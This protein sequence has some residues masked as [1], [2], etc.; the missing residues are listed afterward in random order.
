[1]KFLIVNLFLFFAV[2]NLHANTHKD[3]LLVKLKKE[4][5]NKSIYD[6]QKLLRIEEVKLGFKQKQTDHFNTFLQLFNEYEYYKFDSAYYYGKKLLQEGIRINNKK[7]INESK[8]KLASLLLHAGMFK[9]T[10]DYLKEIN[11]SVLDKKYKYEYYCLKSGAYSNLAIY[12]NDPNFT[13][14]YNQRAVEYLDSAI[15]QCEPNTFDLLFTLGN[16]QVVGGM[17]NKSPTFFLEILKKYEL[18]AH[19]RAR[20]LTA[21]A[22]FY[23]DESQDDQRIALLA[24]SAIWD[25]RSS[26]RETL[27]TLLLA[28]D[29]FRHGDLDNA[30]I[31]IKNSRDDAG[32]YGNRL[33]KLKIESILPDIA[34]QVDMVAQK[35]NNK[36]MF[37]FLATAMI[38]VIVLLISFVIFIQLKKL[39]VKERIIEEKNNELK[40]INEQLLFINDKLREYATVNEKYIGYFFDVIS[41]YILKLDRLKKNV[42]RKIL[43]KRFGEVLP[44]LHDIDIK[45]E[46]ETLFNTFDS[47]F[48]SIF[49][50]FVEVFNSLLNQEDQIWPKAPELLNTDLR[51]FALMRLGIKDVQAIATILEYS[52]N[53]IYVYK[54]RIKAKAFVSGDEFDAR[55]MAVKA[56]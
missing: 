33:R 28:E 41:G 34:A 20:L 32:F 12:N 6:K 17:V 13:R 35:A 24:E 8:V 54:M 14:P 51:I 9:E 27:A 7:K 4:I 31:F 42:E 56:I 40:V 44:A 29:L 37:Y 23:Q 52:V 49:P 45:K 3:S 1:M 2:S 55:I 15:S 36:L 21:L 26:T 50:N 53:T 38:T 30:Y 47:V 25:I 16:R 10:F 11:S 39:R 22:A 19:Q 5:Q 18:T 46:R 48:I 43:A